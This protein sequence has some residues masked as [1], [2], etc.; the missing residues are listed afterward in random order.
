M[1][2]IKNVM[3]PT[4]KAYVDKLP[5]KTQK[6]MARYINY[7]DSGNSL[8]LLRTAQDTLTNWVPKAVFARS[9]SDFADMSFLELSESLL[10][11][12]GPK[13]LG[14][15]IF[16]KLYSK[17]LDENL[18]Q[19]VAI[20][21]ENLLK[22]KNTNFEQNKKIMPV[23][24]AIAISALAIPLLE[25]SLNY[26][27]NIFTLKVFKQGDFN[28]IANLNKEKKEDNEQH[29]K[30]KESATRHFKLSGG[31]FAGCLGLS[32]LFLTKGRNSKLLQSVSE[33]ILDP[34]NKIFK[35]NPE[36]AA[37][38]NKYFSIDFDSADVKDAAG[39]VIKDKFGNAKKQLNLSI[40]QITSCVVIGGFGYFGAAKD[41]GKQNL[42]EVIFRYPITTLYVITGSALFEKAFKY[43]SQKTGAFKEIL[44]EKEVPKLSELPELAEKIADKNKTSSNVEFEKLFKQKTALTAIPSLFG[45]VVMGF[46]V[47]GSSRFFTQYRY[48]K[49]HNNK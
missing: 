44:S 39:N 3:D 11:Y 8:A 14:E 46:F 7:Q 25:Y 21:A 23:K 16:R 41:R 42:L 31:I 34:G 22:N 26:I 4:T 27:K 28:N 17:K 2:N 9:M 20:R 33:I 35:N 29:K 6:I 40:G 38:F 45:L 47:A 12:Y 30:L 5:K 24:A 15:N 10:V 36:K 13:L 18:M 43:I 48:N 19:D 1:T 49:E 32:A 37:K